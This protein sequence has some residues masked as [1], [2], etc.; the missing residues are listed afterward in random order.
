MSSS[1]L[2]ASSNENKFEEVST[3]LSELGISSQFFRCELQE[4]QANNLDEVARFK[5][6]YAFSLCSKPV[7]VEDDGLFIPSLRGFPG[8]YSSFA[9]GTIGNKGILRLLARQRSAF[10]RSIIAYRE[11]EGSVM[12]F[13]AVVH[14]KIS[15]K[16]QGNG[17]GFDPIFIPQGQ[18]MTYSQLKNTKNHIS[19]R[20]LALRKFANWYLHKKKSNDL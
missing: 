1:V 3:I 18:T 13:D 17:W 20:Y 14:G 11:K 9:L 2:F 6:N 7:I 15:K 10:F 12:L 4:I 5:A 16:I 8:P 19:H